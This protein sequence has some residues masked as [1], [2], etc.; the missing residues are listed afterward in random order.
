MASLRDLKAYG[1][2]DAAAAE[3]KERARTASRES[4]RRD[5][6]AAKRASFEREEKRQEALRRKQW[7]EAHPEEVIAE[8]IAKRVVR[9]VVADMAHKTT[10]SMN[11]VAC[12]VA[13]RGCDPPTPRAKPE[14]WDAKADGADYETG[15]SP[16]KPEVD[17]NSELSHFQRSLQWDRSRM[18]GSEKVEAYLQHRMERRKAVPNPK[19]RLDDAVHLYLG[20]NTSKTI[21]ALRTKYRTYRHGKE[22]DRGCAP[23]TMPEAIAKW[24]KAE[25][26]REKKAGEWRKPE[27]SL[28]ARSVAPLPTYDSADDKHNA[29]LLGACYAASPYQAARDATR[30]GYRDDLVRVPRVQH[31]PQHPVS[32]HFYS[33]GTVLPSTG[34]LCKTEPGQCAPAK[35][36]GAAWRRDRAYGCSVSDAVGSHVTPYTL[37]SSRSHFSSDAKHPVDGSLGP[38]EGSLHFKAVPASTWFRLPS[39]ACRAFHGDGVFELVSANATHNTRRDLKFEA[40][41]VPRKDVTKRRYFGYR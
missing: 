37:H 26:R 35:A 13:S 39:E 1:D 38:E 17:W 41:P 19:T 11:L 32:S 29:Y 36:A 30:S 27:W 3:E 22:V 25:V 23:Q 21:R 33:G 20:A 28:D 9:R 8:R 2:Y 4:K 24:R 7:R 31:L 10:W 34:T 18:G 14:D 16:K 5:E 12:R 6:A 40:R 15:Q